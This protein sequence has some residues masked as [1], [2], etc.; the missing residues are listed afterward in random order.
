MHVVPADFAVWKICGAHE[1]YVEIILKGS[2]FD[3]EC[4]DSSC[5]LSESL[6]MVVHKIAAIS[7]ETLI[8]Q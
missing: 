6:S 2:F 5:M 4:R 8:I 3:G 1:G 7:K